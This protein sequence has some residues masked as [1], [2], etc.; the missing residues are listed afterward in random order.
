MNLLTIYKDQI[1]VKYLKII[2]DI[3]W[4][5]FDRHCPSLIYGIIHEKESKEFILLKCNIRIK[6]LFL[7]KVYKLISSDSDYIKSE[8]VLSKNEQFVGIYQLTHSKQIIKPTFFML[9]LDTSNFLMFHFKDIKFPP[10][11]SN[12][13][14]DY[15][16][17]NFI[18]FK[19]IHSSTLGWLVCEW[20]KKNSDTVCFRLNR[21]LLNGNT[22]T[23]DMDCLIDNDICFQDSKSPSDCFVL[24]NRAYFTYPNDFSV[25]IYD[26]STKSFMQKIQMPKGSRCCRD[27][28]LTNCNVIFVFNGRRPYFKLLNNKVLDQIPFDIPPHETF[29]R[30]IVSWNGD[31]LLTVPNERAQKMDLVF[32]CLDYC[33]LVLSLQY[34]SFCKLMEQFSVE[35]QCREYFFTKQLHF[36]NMLTRK[37]FGP[38]WTLNHLETIITEP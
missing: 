35:E 15:N 5:G 26:I 29:F 19:L 3:H 6:R 36:S 18:N 20:Y 7:C 37:C 13:K 12:S 22:N 30:W 1:T 27:I 14:L 2:T 11:K 25:F 38:L 10:K 34:L 16:F 31:I 24:E 4:L 8:F 32:G 33:G 23:F 28:L 21:I 17:Q 9:D